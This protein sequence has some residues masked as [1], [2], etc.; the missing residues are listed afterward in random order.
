MPLQEKP[1]YL[2]CEIMKTSAVIIMLL[3]L[4]VQHLTAADGLR[5]LEGGL[6][7]W[8]ILSSQCSQTKVVQVTG[9]RVSFQ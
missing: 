2:K 9:F 7:Q 1:F 3:K 8:A 5:G 4:T 6:S